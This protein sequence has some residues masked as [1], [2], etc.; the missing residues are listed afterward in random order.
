LF[1]FERGNIIADEDLIAGMNTYRT[2]CHCISLT[3][4]VAKMKREDF[5]RLENQPYSW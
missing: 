1:R 2:T 4:L 3:G 5:I